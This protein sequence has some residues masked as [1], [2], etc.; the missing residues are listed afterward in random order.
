MPRPVFSS[1]RCRL[2]VRA[3]DHYGEPFTLG[4]P[5]GPTGDGGRGRCSP[6]LD[7]DAA[8]PA[9]DAALAAAGFD[10]QRPPTGEG[11]A[12]ARWEAQSALADL[13]AHLPAHLAAHLP[14][15][16]TATVAALVGDLRRRAAEEHTSRRAGA[17]TVSTIHKAKGLERDVVFLPR[18][19]EGSLPSVFATARPRSPRSAACCTSG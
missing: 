5:V 1:K 13:A 12:R 6:E 11:A 17:V 10:A 3:A 14:A 2:R 8:L 7:D 4:W 18:L 19:T 15:D 9:L 16:L